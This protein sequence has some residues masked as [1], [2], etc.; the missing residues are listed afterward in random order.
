LAVAAAAFDDEQKSAKKQLQRKSK[1]VQYF[2]D[3]D[4]KAFRTKSWTVSKVSKVP[5]QLAHIH[6]C[7][8]AIQGQLMDQLLFSSAHPLTLYSLL[9]EIAANPGMASCPNGGGRQPDTLGINLDWPQNKGRRP[10]LS[11]NNVTIIFCDPSFV[12]GPQQ[13]TKRVRLT[14]HLGNLVH[15]PPFYCC[16]CSLAVESNSCPW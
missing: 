13:T 1:L 5:D 11:R 6:E 10:N 12:L 8:I 9:Q 16:N 15:S 3:D 4:V 7:G 2:D 14:H